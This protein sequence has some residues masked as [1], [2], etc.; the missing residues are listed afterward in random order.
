MAGDFSLGI[1]S[2]LSDPNEGLTTWL[3][4]IDMTNSIDVSPVPEPAT[5]L[6]LGTGLV[7]LAGFRKR[8]RQS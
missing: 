8:F 1:V 7:G 6:L 4:Q 2:D 3:Y 5:M